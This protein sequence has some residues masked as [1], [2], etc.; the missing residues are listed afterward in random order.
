M[1][2]IPLAFTL[3]FTAAAPLAQVTSSSTSTSTSVSSSSSASSSVSLTCGGVGEDDQQRMK[4]AAAKKGLLV[5]F[6]GA[7]GVYLADV[8]VEVRRGSEVIARSRCAGPMLLLDLS[9]PGK[10]EIAATAQGRTQRQ[11]VTVGGKP[12]SIV[13]RWPGQ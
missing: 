12:A 11:V 2:S 13:M 3:V 8:D 5:T 4:A 10:Y 1:K 9:P 7:G 6:A